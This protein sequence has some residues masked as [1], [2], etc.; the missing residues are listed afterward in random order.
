MP[1]V[2]RVGPYRF[3]F[4]AGDRAE[5]E[6]VHVSRDN[7]IA[8]FWLNPVRLARSG[9]FRRADIRRIQ[10]VVEANRETLLEAWYDY[11][12]G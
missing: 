7:L 5:P 11:F 12:N 6:H 9:G 4:Y 8:K 10:S 2:L 3:S 1:T